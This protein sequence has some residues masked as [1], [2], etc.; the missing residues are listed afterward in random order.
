[1]RTQTA[2]TRRGPRQH[3][4]CT[5]CGKR[6]GSTKD[7]GTCT[8]YNRVH[9]KA[10]SITERLGLRLKGLRLHAKLTQAEMA[11]AFGVDRVYIVHMEAGKVSPTINMLE[12]LALGFR[13]T[14]SELLAGL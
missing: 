10:L 8:R 12:V 9:V 13:V 4:P 2:S 3:P 5:N 7:C 14:L 11:T 6:K 1:M